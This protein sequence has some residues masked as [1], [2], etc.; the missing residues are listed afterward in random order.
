MFA[1]LSEPIQQLAA[2]AFR[3]FRQNP[4]HPALRRHALKDNDKGRHR[5]GSFSVS[6]TMQYRALYVI[7]GDVNVWY[8]IGTHNAYENFIGKK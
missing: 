7:D 4:D 5:K 8:W 3:V 6:I 2:S 1:K